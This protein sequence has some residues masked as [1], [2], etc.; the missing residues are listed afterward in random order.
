MSTHDDV[1]VPNA[2]LLY[3]RDNTGPWVVDTNQVFRLLGWNFALAAG[4]LPQYNVQAATPAW[5]YR[6]VTSA[7]TGLDLGPGPCLYGGIFCLAAGDPGA[8]RDN[9]VAGAGNI[10]HGAGAMAINTGPELSIKCS[11]G[12]TVPWTS[13]IFIVKIA[14]T[15]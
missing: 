13:G 5:T 1:V 12:V 2:Q 3:K 14:P 4:E 10:I 7:A 9:T 8:V 6:Y 11:L 15:V